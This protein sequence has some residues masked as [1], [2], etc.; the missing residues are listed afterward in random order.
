MTNGEAQ[1]VAALLN[2]RNKLARQHSE[3]SVLAHADDYLTK[4]L[5]GRIIAAVQ[6]K[7]VQWYQAELCHLTVD[8]NYEGKG[9][10]REMAALA[11]ARARELGARVIQCTIREGNAGSERL[12]RSAGYCRISTFY[13]GDSGNYVAIWQKTLVTK[14]ES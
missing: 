2:H 12:F 13:N 3:H 6:V 10:A 14:P 5:D 9:H 4:T 11:E 1:E 8:E 7:R